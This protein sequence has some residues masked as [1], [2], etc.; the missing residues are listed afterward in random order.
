MSL[1]SQWAYAQAKLCSRLVTA[2]G[3]WVIFEGLTYLGVTS[4]NSPFPH[5]HFVI[6]SSSVGRRPATSGLLGLDSQPAPGKCSPWC[7][8]R[9]AVRAIRWPLG[10][11]AAFL[12]H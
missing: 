7:A 8:V 5:L 12:S 3:F 6:R 9:V 11:G 1:G 10:E 4:S 2:T